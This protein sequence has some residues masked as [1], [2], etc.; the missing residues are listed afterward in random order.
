MDGRMQKKI[1][2]KYKRTQ[3]QPNDLDWFHTH[4]H[5]KYSWL[6][7]MGSVSELVAKAVTQNQ[8]A[9]TLTEHG[10]LSSAF[11]LYKECKKNNIKPFIGSELYFSFD[12]TDDELKKTRYHLILIALN[13]DGYKSL[14]QLNNKSHTRESY[15]RKP[16]IDWTDL[17]KL[18]ETGESK[19][20]VLLTGCFFGLIQQP[21]LNQGLN[22][23]EAI[24]N[25]LSS[26]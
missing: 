3:N 22:Q 17:E 16:L 10:V 15:H 12:A 24:L 7:G 23:A 14:V 2:G 4:A 8:P 18:S 21:M 13:T 1:S 20:L 25:R 26:L 5:S 19:N 6:D 9:L 11:E